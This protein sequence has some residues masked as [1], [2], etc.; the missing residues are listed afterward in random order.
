[1]IE[2]FSF[3]MQNKTIY[4][5]VGALV[6]FIILMIAVYFMIFRN[7]KGFTNIKSNDQHTD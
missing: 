2:S 7:K 1:M 3:G 4:I 6:A 5:G